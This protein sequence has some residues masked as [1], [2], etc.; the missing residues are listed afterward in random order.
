MTHVGI[1]AVFPPLFDILEYANVATLHNAL[2]VYY[3]WQP[4]SND[5]EVLSEYWSFLPRHRSAKGTVVLSVQDISSQD[6]A[7]CCS[8][9]LCKLFQ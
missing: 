7:T 4:D 2:H 3:T 1:F 8:Q 6:S 5:A 9:K